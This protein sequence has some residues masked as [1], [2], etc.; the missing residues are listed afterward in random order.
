[1][2]DVLLVSIQTRLWDENCYVMAAAAGSEAIIVDPG[3]GAAAAVEQVATDHNLTPV[4]VLA[5]HGHIDHVADAAA[6]ADRW[7]VPV[8]IHPDDRILLTEPAV[9]LDPGAAA[10]VTELFGAPTIAAPARVEEIAD[11][12]R[13]EL[14][15]FTW[16]VLH[17]PGHRPGCVMYAV[18]TPDGPLAFTGDVLFAGSIGRTDLPGGSMSAMVRSLRDVV[19]GPN[20]DD[21][22]TLLPGHGPQTTLA[23]ERRSNPYLQRRFLERYR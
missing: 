1:V 11:H 14:A 10:F 6:L 18:A 17:A 15:G 19:L 22:T 5:S 7:A 21:T 23:A 16:T 4:A 8:Y 20:L 2:L 12:D 3:W 13:L 9:G